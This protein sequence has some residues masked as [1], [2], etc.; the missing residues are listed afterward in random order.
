M[1]VQFFVPNDYTFV[2]TIG[3]STS[4]FQVIHSTINSASLILLQT[5]EKVFVIL[6]DL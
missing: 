4:I 3:L 2:I 6:H 5:L 1:K